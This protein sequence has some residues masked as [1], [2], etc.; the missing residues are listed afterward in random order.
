VL[1]RHE[2]APHTKVTSQLDY[3]FRVYFPCA[4]LQSNPIFLKDL[5]GVSG[6]SVGE[7]QARDP[8]R[9]DDCHVPQRIAD[10]AGCDRPF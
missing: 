3:L 1:S 4:T 9:V 2:F 5:A 10:G 8:R 6:L 7:S